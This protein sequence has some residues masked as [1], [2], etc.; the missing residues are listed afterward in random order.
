MSLND[1]RRQEDREVG[2]RAWLN[3]VAEM[4][5]AV[6]PC[7]R[8]SEWFSDD[9]REQAKAS[10]M[11]EG[12]QLLAACRSFGLAA[13]PPHGVYGGLAP[14]DRKRIRRETKGQAA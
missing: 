6:I 14:K 10:R 8:G 9:P 1:A 5:G 12:C 13:N 4:E 3:L 7:Q 2:L 11:C